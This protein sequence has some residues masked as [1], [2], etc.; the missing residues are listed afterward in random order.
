M[1]P[2][3]VPR[4]VHITTVP[5]S[6]TFLK[7]QVGMM[8][9][10]GFDVHAISSPG[11]ELDAFG[12]A[13]R[14]RVSAVEMKRRIAPLHDI[15]AL[16]KLTAILRGIRPHVVHA[17]TPK[18]GL[19]GMLAAKAAGVPVRV[20]QMRGLPLM[21]AEWP[22]RELLRW[23]EIVSCGIA[24]SVLCNSRSL[25]SV[26]I[27]QG[28][29]AAEK[30]AV[31]ANGSGQGVDATTR[32]DPAGYDGDA[33][34]TMRRELGIPDGALVLGYVGRIVR[35][36]GISELGAAWAM[37]RAS[38]P[39]L[40]LLMIGPFEP[41][42]PIPEDLRRRLST[43]PRVHLVGENWDTPPLYSVMDVL[44]LPT[45]REGFPNVPLEAAAMEVPVVATRIPGCVDAVED[46]VTGTLVPVKDDRALANAIEAY[47]RNG[48]LRR[49]HGTA[50]RKR[51]LRDFRQEDIWEATYREY[52]RLLKLSR[53]ERLL[54][55][56]RTV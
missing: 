33:R 25:R 36:K 2:D 27:E 18:G 42:D 1:A 21:G 13:H 48:E 26:A 44:A 51:V 24:Q 11:E 30:I 5:M 12:E 56:G 28:I 22:K 38:H 55:R 34:R 7:G 4:L 31:L 46:H 29:C 37:L 10:R 54:P 15:G 23:T 35:D 40:H 16:S 53:R 9:E 19:L 14:V 49:L 6:L 50:G 32:F 17:H 43:D 39:D 52:C 47:L 20:Y 41:Q 45:Y 8:R 3:E